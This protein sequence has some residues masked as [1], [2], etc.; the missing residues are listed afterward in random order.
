V[1][2][3]KLRAI[4]SC[5]TKMALQVGYTLFPDLEVGSLGDCP[6][7]CRYL[8]SNVGD[9]DRRG[10]VELGHGLTGESLELFLNLKP[11]K[12]LAAEPQGM[13]FISMFQNANCPAQILGSFRIE[14][15]HRQER[16]SVKPDSS[17]IYLVAVSF[18]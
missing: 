9:D 10:E 8:G 18:A 14:P 17:R 15:I 3:N 6:K 13:V 4:Q 5:R 11:R 1:D 12:S 16:G 2:D 7:G